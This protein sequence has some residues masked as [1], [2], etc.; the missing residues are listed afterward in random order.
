MSQKL[1]EAVERAYWRARACR[2]ASGEQ[3][4]EAEAEEEEREHRRSR[5]DS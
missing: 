1:G 4:A 2:R 5:L 3:G